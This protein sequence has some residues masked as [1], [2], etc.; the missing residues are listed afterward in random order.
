MKVKYIV[1]NPHMTPSAFQAVVNGV[2][3]AATVEALEVEL[4]AVDLA[5]GGIKLRFIGA[6]VEPAKALF[7][8]DCVVAASF[9]ATDEKMPTPQ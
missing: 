7:Q 4:R 1:Q 9:E 5:N 6:D 3:M 8:N 2:P